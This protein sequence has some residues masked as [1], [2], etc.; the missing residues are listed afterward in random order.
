MHLEEND[1]NHH[2][3]AHV[4][5]FSSDDISADLACDLVTRVDIRRMCGTLNHRPRLPFWVDLKT[6]TDEGSAI[7]DH[8]H[9]DRSS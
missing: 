6:Q 5:R 3:E 4:D 8:S 2:A 7:P 9:T 1:S